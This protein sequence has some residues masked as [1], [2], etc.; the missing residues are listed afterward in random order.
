[1]YVDETSL[2]LQVLRLQR[3]F[4]CIISLVQLLLRWVEG[5][6]EKLL[7]KFS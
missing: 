2:G 4:R 5:V 7:R 3:M 1:M 6:W